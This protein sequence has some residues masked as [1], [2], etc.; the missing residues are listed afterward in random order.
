MKIP[1]FDSHCDTASLLTMK[2]GQLLKNDGH[3]DLERGQAYRYAQ[4][5]AIFGI[6]EFAKKPYTQLFDETYS[7]LTQQLEQNAD[8]V[9]FCRTAADARAANAAG[10]T[11]AF[12]T[13]EDANLLDCSIEGL[14]RGH[15]LGVKAVAITWNFKNALSGTNVTGEGLTDLGR[16]F[17][18]RMYD[19]GVIVDVS[20]I[21]DAGF[22]DICDI[23]SGPIVATHSN[24]RAVFG[25][26]RNLTD[27]MY[28]E[29]I[30]SG[31][32]AGI[33]LYADFIAEDADIDSVLRHMEHFL[34]LGGEKCL[35]MGGDLD[36]CERLP[37]GMEGVQDIAKLYNEAERRFGKALA[38]DVFYNNLMRVVES[39]EK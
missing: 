21:S 1:Y 6:A 10:K 39:V 11:A 25:H 9:S 20:H 12:V 8:I 3:I 7:Y 36:G 13:V 38:E 5:F 18:R 32:T 31:G 33:N 35:S 23:A 28:R 37:R 34:D 15:E 30:R 27:D 2:Q 19:L 22:F 26:Q 29:I 4:F 24:S 17:V 14:E 16:A